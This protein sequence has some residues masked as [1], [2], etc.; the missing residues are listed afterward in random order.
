MG[1]L[2]DMLKKVNHINDDHLFFATALI[3]SPLHAICADL[4]MSEA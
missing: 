3:S 4:Y 1:L 2:D